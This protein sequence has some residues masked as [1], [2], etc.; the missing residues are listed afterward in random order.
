[1]VGKTKVTDYSGNEKITLENVG[2][3]EK[4]LS[5]IFSGLQLVDTEMGF[6]DFPISEITDYSGN[7]KGEGFQSIIFVG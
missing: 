3:A 6:K 5:K 2:L 7:E 4:E 1:M